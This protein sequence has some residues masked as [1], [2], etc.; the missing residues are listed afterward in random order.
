VAFETDPMLFEL[1]TFSPNLVRSPVYSLDCG[2]PPSTVPAATC[3]TYRH[4]PR[5]VAAAPDK[6]ALPTSAIL[7]FEQA[8]GAVPC[9]T[10]EPGVLPDPEQ[11]LSVGG[12]ADILDVGACSHPT[13]SSSPKSS[14]RTIEDL[15]S[16]IRAKAQPNQSLEEAK[17]VTTNFL[18]SVR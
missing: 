13:V 9:H 6:A 3:K 15:K 12:P 5:S 18:A 8:V 17:A 11:I 14:R 4:R 16:R 10:C 2:A 7:N 1:E